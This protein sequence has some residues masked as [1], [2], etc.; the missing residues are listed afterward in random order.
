VK[1]HGLWRFH[2]EAAEVRKRFPDMPAR[3]WR[4]DEID[5]T[6]RLIGVLHSGYGRTGQHSNSDAIVRCVRRYARAKN[7]PLRT[8]REWNALCHIVADRAGFT[9]HMTL[10]A[11][12]ITDAPRDKSVIGFRNTDDL[13]RPTVAH[14]YHEALQRANKIALIRHERLSA[15]A[16][17][18]PA[19]QPTLM[20][21]RFA[22]K[23]CAVCGRDKAT[24]RKYLLD[25]SRYVR[26]SLQPI[27]DEIGREFYLCFSHRMAFCKLVN[28]ARKADELRLSINR[29]RRS[30]NEST[31]VSARTDGSP[32]L[33]HGGGDQ[34]RCE[35]ERGA[36]SVERSHADH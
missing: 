19:R 12:L 2:H 7:L 29:T 18:T 13:C 28:A 17:F 20:A 9:H 31:K 15:E 5:R 4:D 16:A 21:K 11:V 3:W 26:E 32:V 30:I 33:H 10:N 35:G 34:W 14:S 36:D 6:H 22:A 25:H 24:R 8:V 1:R 23:E 27:A